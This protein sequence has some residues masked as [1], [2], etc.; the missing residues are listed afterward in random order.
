MLTELKDAILVLLIISFHDGTK[1]EFKVSSFPSETPGVSWLLH[2]SWA[3]TQ[4]EMRNGLRFSR[5]FLGN[6]IRLSLII[7]REKGD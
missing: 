6:D 5:R 3:L 7:I 4:T 1:L 2:K